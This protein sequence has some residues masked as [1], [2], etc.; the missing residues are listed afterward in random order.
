MKATII[1]LFVFFISTPSFSQSNW[2]IEL[3]VEYNQMSKKGDYVKC[4][5]IASQLRDGYIRVNDK[6]RLLRSIRFT[7]NAHYYLDNIDSSFYYLNYGIL[8]AQENKINNEDY[9]KININKAQI[10]E[11]YKLFEDALIFYKQSLNIAKSS[12]SLLADSSLLKTIELGI[13]SNQNRF[14]ISLPLEKISLENKKV[15]NVSYEENLESQDMNTKVPKFNSGHT[16]WITSSLVISNLVYSGS[17]NGYIKL[18][19][20]KSRKELKELFIEKTSVDVIFQFSNDTIIAGLGNGRIILFDKNLKV[21]DLIMNQSAGIEDI[22]KISD[23]TIIVVQDNM[24][25]HIWNINSRQVIKSIAGNFDSFSQALVADNKLLTFGQNKIFMWDLENFN[26]L[27]KKIA[28]F[29]NIKS[30]AFEN[31]NRI[32]A[33]CSM[34]KTIKLWSLNNLQEI[35]TLSGHKSDVHKVEF[36]EDRRFVVSCGFDG[37]II[38]WDALSL[39]MLKEINFANREFTDIV[40]IENFVFVSD[41][42]GWIHKVDLEKLMLIKSSKIHNAFIKKID[43]IS[44]NQIVSISFDK[45]IKILNSTDL[46]ILHSFIGIHG[47]EAFHLG[48]DVIPL[49]AIKK[50]IVHEPIRH[51]IALIG[52]DNSIVNYSIDRPFEEF[53]YQSGDSLISYDL[54]FTSSEDAVAI[55]NQ[56]GEIQFNFKGLTKNKKI[57][58]SLLKKLIYL[59][60]SKRIVTIDNKGFVYLYDIVKDEV[61][62]FKRFS[63]LHFADIRKIDQDKVLLIAD[64][65]FIVIGDNHKSLKKY[66]LS[67]NHLFRKREFEISVNQSNS[68]IAFHELK[69]NNVEIF[70]L[71]QK[72]KSTIV[73]DGYEIF[74]IKWLNNET[75]YITDKFKQSYSLFISGKISK[76]QSYAINLTI[77]LNQCDYL[78]AGNEL[79][80]IDST[81]IS[82]LVYK[83]ENNITD[84][85]YDEGLGVFVLANDNYTNTILNKNFKKMYTRTSLPKN[86]Y[87]IKLPN[88]PYYMCS[89]DASKMLHYVTP[90]LKVIGFDQLDPVYN[91]PDIVLD[92]IGKYFGNQDRGMIEEYKKAWEKRIERL[93]LDKGKLS[94]GEIAVPNADIVNADQIE[95]EDKDGS[96]IIHVKANDLKYTLRR[97]NVLVNEVPVYGSDGISISQLNTRQLE[98]TDTIALGVGENKIQVSVMNELGLENFKYATYVNYTPK[99]D[100]VSKTY[101]VG[102]GVNEF[103]N[104]EHNLKYCVKDV[105]DLAQAFAKNQSKVDTLVFTNSEVTKENILALKSYLQKNTTVN[106]KVIISCSSHGL[107]DDSLN[108]YLATYDVDFAHPEK[109]G[110]AYED[111]EGLLDGIPARQKL[112]LLDACNSGENE[113]M[114]LQNNSS[115]QL[116]QAGM[117]GVNVEIV[118][119]EINTFHQMTELFVNVRNNTGSVIIAASGGMQSAQEGRVVEGKKIEN[120]AFTYSVLEYLAKEFNN[121]E[122]CTVNG[123]KN[124]V[125]SRVEE[126]TNGEQKPTSR[127]ETM[128][129][130]WE[131][132]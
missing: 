85:A 79:F 105:Q 101:Y 120:G 55:C 122:K 100:I 80:E 21:Y 8:Y 2:L 34:D 15:E 82:T 28:H 124:Y 25:A 132:K 13:R 115:D 23:S 69:S 70:N 72:K 17:F 44:E 126:I 66:F 90:S 16:D 43:L 108:F 76:V 53:L 102:I 75:L 130:D 68:L 19:D 87:F 60:K 59:E 36:S 112:L 27:Q 118:N 58:N 46:R 37:K 9:L 123:M 42:E 48:Q 86:N 45:S 119:E 39:A 127:Q 106:D 95:Y 12:A 57:S 78:S 121:Q 67:Q 98:R 92:S 104:S 128:E 74:S 97:Y 38:I 33:S 93:G 109:R 29:D 10:L 31:K 61:F 41:N 77:S 24:F 3:E 88:S 96:V 54:F 73:W 11:N 20:K 4:L 83:D 1:M 107:L 52:Y 131:V 129:V 103:K 35:G 32:I 56:S 110:L 65:G 26:L 99:N 84:L 6:I 114:F 7:A 40:M 51:R 64:N 71:S 49:W 125:E 30:I 117:K 18:W 22:K 47:T 111:L 62:R 5:S 116:A 91:R 63:R 113:R 50:K 14:K 94:T 81:L 89:K